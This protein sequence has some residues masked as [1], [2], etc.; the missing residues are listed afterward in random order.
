MI[1][2]GILLPRK[3]YSSYILKTFIMYHHFKCTHSHTPTIGQCV[4]NVLNEMCTYKDTESLPTLVKKTKYCF[5]RN[6]KLFLLK[7]L[8]SLTSDLKSMKTSKEKYDYERFKIPRS[9]SGQYLYEIKNVHMTDDDE[10]DDE[11]QEKLTEMSNFVNSL[12]G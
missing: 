2:D 1:D 10:T 4:I 11:L 8:K 3:K 7:H 5:Q 6:R 12:T 9:V